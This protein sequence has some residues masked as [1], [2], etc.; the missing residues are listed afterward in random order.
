MPFEAGMIY[1]R[2]LGGEN[3]SLDALLAASKPKCGIARDE[4][5]AAPGSLAR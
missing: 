5:V 3:H 1:F 4:D 2:V